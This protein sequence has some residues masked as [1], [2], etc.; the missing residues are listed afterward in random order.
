MWNEWKARPFPSE[1]S[2]TVVA[3]ICVTSL[4]TFA[5]GCIDAFI[6]NNGRLD[7]HR[8]SVLE[9]CKVDLEAVVSCLD[10]TAKN[11]FNDLLILAK[12]VLQLAGQ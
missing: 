8:T 10:G 1:Y 4:D 12:R 6:S 7:E 3:G 9:Q 5:A 11:Y 2:D